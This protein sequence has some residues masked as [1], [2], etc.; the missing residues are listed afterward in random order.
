M[1]ETNQIEVSLGAKAEAAFQLMAQDLIQAAQQTGRPLVIWKDGRVQEVSA[2]EL[3]AKG[4]T[5]ASQPPEA[6]TT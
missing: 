2:Q 6:Q 4:S 1:S 5:P 3:A